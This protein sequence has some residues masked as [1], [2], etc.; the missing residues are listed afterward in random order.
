MRH[1][2]LLQQRRVHSDQTR[3]HE[4]RGRRGANHDAA[5]DGMPAGISVCWDVVARRNTVDYYYTYESPLRANRI[6]TYAKR[7]DW[8]RKTLLRAGKDEHGSRIASHFQRD[9]GAVLYFSPKDIVWN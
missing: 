1:T 8:V 3:E 5:A 7:S 9:S 4:T 6:A 2:R